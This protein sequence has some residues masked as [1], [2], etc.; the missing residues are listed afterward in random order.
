MDQGQGGGLDNM[1]QEIIIGVR[2]FRLDQNTIVEDNSKGDRI[3]TRNRTQIK[4]NQEG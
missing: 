4:P 2:I 3:G 1:K